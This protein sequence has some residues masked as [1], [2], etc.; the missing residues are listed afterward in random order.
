L[1]D[2]FD[3]LDL[4]AERPRLLTAAEILL[5]EPPRRTDD[6]WLERKARGDAAMKAWLQRW[7]FIAVL[8]VT[9]VVVLLPLV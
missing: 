4:L 3:A 9:A 5:P 1:G 2:A 7:M 6:E 8:V